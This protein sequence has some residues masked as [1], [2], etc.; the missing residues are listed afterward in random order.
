MTDKKEQCT[1]P[2]S[3]RVDKN[4]IDVAD[5]ALDRIALVAAAIP[6]LGVDCDDSA[7]RGAAYV[8]LG[9]VEELRSFVRAVDDTI[10]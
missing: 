4:A 7:A 3:I 5:Q 10:K 6:S 1:M 8:L 2:D 9:A